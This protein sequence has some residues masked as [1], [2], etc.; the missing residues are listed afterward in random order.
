MFDDQKEALIRTLEAEGAPLSLADAKDAVPGGGIA[1]EAAINQYAQVVQR[2]GEEYVVGVADGPSY[3]IDEAEA[4]QQPEPDPEPDASEE[5]PQPSSEPEPAQESSEAVVTDVSRDVYQVGDLLITVDPEEELAGEWTGDSFLGIPVLENGSDGIPKTMI[6]YVPVPVGKQTSDAFAARVIGVLNRPLLLEGE[7]GTGKNLLADYLL[8]Q[9]N[10]KKQRINFG[11]DVSVYSLI[12]EKDIVDGDTIF[13]PGDL[14][15]AALFGHTAILDEVNMATGDVTSFIHGLTEEPGNRQLELWGTPVTLRDLPV[16]RDEVKEHGSV[17]AAQRL[18]WDD[19]EH[20]GRYIH[21]EF[22]I[23]AT[24]NPLEYADTKQ[25]ND[26][27]RDRFVAMEHPYLTSAQSDVRKALETEAALLADATDA[28]P[29]DV[30]PL[31]RLAKTL[32]DA[33]RQANAISCPITHRALKK[34]VEIAGPE[35]D[36]MSFKEAAKEIMVGYASLKSDKQYI[37]DAIDDEL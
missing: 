9:T 25:M 14:A 37:E 33:R 36:F 4:S 11:S 26:A 16:S 22:R 32:R 34:T 35:E 12:G 21:P 2:D 20:L 28:D 5:D 6:D 23:M 19:D 8:E 1:A 27:F 10:R 13:T 24:C 15:K 18:K 3:T 17:Y 31:V 29:S 7:A 30:L